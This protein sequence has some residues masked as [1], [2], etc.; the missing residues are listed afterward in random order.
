M[1]DAQKVMEDLVLAM[2]HTDHALWFR[3]PRVKVQQPPRAR[4][5]AIQRCGGFTK[6]VIRQKNGADALYT[7]YTEH[8]LL[9]LSP[10]PQEAAE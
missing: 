7:L 4:M 1:S 9:K 2:P 3:H 10:E 8:A 6:R 5:R